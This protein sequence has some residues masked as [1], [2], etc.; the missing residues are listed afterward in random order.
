MRDNRQTPRFPCKGS[1]H[2]DHEATSIIFDLV[3]L[4]H[5]GACLSMSSSQ[6]SP[7]EEEEAVKGQFS[8]KGEDINFNGR[9]C[10]ST[11]DG[12]KVFFGV[13][14]G[15]VQFELVDRVLMNIQVI[16]APPMD[17]FNI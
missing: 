8:T 10:W 6:W 15:E 9:I 13:Q 3:N 4:S 5:N 7:F 14:F 2:L 1:G 17:P 11:D 12:S 16:D